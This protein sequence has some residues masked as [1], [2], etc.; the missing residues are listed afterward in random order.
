MAP[1]L[2]RAAVATESRSAPVSRR[3]RADLLSGPVADRSFV[4]DVSPELPATY[5][6]DDTLRTAIHRTR[7]ET[8]PIRRG[9][10]RP[11]D[12]PMAVGPAY[13]DD[14][15]RRARDTSAASQTPS[16]WANAEPLALR[17]AGMTDGDG[18]RT[19]GER[20]A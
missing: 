19:G 3:A 5:R 12:G 6:I 1:R 17:P 14:R 18:G 16:C 9:V 20:W 8:R 11:R 15:T 7:Y 10:R 2:G 4:T 13:R